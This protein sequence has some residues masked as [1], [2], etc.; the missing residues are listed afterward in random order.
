M[1]ALMVTLI[2]GYAL[3]IGLKVPPLLRELADDSP[4]SLFDLKAPLPDPP[5][6]SSPVRQR[7]IQPRGGNPPAPAR[8]RPDM[9]EDSPPPAPAVAPPPLV[10]TPQPIAPS[11]ASSVGT[12]AGAAQGTGSPGTGGQGDGSG[13]GGSGQ[14]AGSG[15][16]DGGRF[17]RARQTG[18]RFRNSDFPQSARG[19]GRL[20]IGVRYAI[21][22]SG[23][24]DT[25]EIIETS[26]YAD[27][28]AMTCRIIIERYRFRPARDPD[29]YAVTE[30]REEDYRWRVR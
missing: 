12:G 11:S 13:S 1:A 3:V 5:E 28:D 23:H 25:C 24:V 14:G 20:K 30:V 9:K 17:S 26:G 2:I 16:G 10:P 27:V 4:L 7:A 8:P 19:A 29:G 18:G 21:G 6:A 15:E 22:P